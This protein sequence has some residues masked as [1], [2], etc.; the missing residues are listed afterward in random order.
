MLTK[1]KLNMNIFNTK[2]GIKIRAYVKVLRGPQGPNNPIKYLVNGLSDPMWLCS[3]IK[4]MY[5]LKHKTWFFHFWKKT[6]VVSF[7]NSH[8]SVIDITKFRY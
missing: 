5:V 6:T 8:V 3:K 1:R 4:K 7:L 2:K